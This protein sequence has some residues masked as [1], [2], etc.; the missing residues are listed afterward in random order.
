MEGPPRKSFPLLLRV[1]VPW[2][3]VLAYLAGVALERVMPM[4]MPRSDVARWSGVAGGMLFAAGAA[5]ATWSLVLFRR[6]RTTTIPGRRSAALVTA[7]PYR[8]TRNPMYVALTLAYVGE[9]GLLVQ[10]WPLVL[11]PFVLAYLNRIVIPIEEGR[12]AEV[13]GADYERYRAGVRR[14]V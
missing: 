13:F 4:G 10:V 5:L 2:V 12:L 3:F 6:A 11:L 9:T 14:W 7:G 8:F 1:P